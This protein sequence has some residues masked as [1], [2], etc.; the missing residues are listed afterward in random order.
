M[1]LLLEASLA[2]MVNSPR[3]KLTALSLPPPGL[4]LVYRGSGFV[5]LFFLLESAAGNLDL[6]FFLW[7]RSR[8]LLR[9]PPPCLSSRGESSSSL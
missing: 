6:A 9:P 2:L 5:F 3:A 7:R 8:R 4:R 1:L